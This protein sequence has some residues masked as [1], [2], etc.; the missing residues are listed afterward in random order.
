VAPRLNLSDGGKNINTIM[1]DGWF[2]DENGDIV[3][4]SFRN[5]QGEQKG[6]KTILQERGLWLNGVT[7]FGK[8]LDGLD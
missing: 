7:M 6:L 1:R 2:L 5:V 3:T 4:Q 8:I